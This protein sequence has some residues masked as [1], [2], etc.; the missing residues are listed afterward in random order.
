MNGRLIVS[1]PDTE[2]SG[3]MKPPCAVVVADAELEFVAGVKVGVIAGGVATGV[4]GVNTEG[5][6]VDDA[7]CVL[8]CTVEISTVA[9]GKPEGSTKV[10]TAGEGV[11]VGSVTGTT[12]G[13][14]VSAAWT[15]GGVEE[16]FIASGVFEE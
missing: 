10:N 13:I 6:T 8:S 11:L 9:T 5:D 14:P 15:P 16:V 4:E 7:A 1:D 3:P 12:K 2:N